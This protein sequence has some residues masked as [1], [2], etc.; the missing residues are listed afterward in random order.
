MTARHKYR[1]ASTTSW[2]NHAYLTYWAPMWSVPFSL[3]QCMRYLKMKII[4]QIFLLKL[5]VGP[6]Q[7][8]NMRNIV[9]HGFLEEDG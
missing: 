8:A 6:P 4:V 1:D 3:L 9:W 7:G 2:C 5:I